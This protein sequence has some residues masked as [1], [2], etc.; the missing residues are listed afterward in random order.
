[1]SDWLS[2]EYYEQLKA[3]SDSQPLVIPDGFT[4]IVKGDEER[5]Q[6][7]QDKTGE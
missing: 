7:E 4:F 3:W 5:L 6:P 1:M 2:V